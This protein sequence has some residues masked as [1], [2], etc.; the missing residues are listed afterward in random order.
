MA[1][2][3]E[4]HR[5]LDR[6]SQLGE[7]IH[8]AGEIGV[9]V[10]LHGLLQRIG[11]HRQRVR[12]HP[13]YQVVELRGGRGVAELC[14]PDVADQKDVG[15]Y[16]AHRERR[17]AVR[18]DQHHPLRTQHHADAQLLGGGREIA[19][20]GGRKFRAAGHRSD[21]NRCGQSLAQ[22]LGGQVNPGEAG[23]GQRHIRQVESFQ[24][25]GSGDVLHWIAQA[26]VNVALLAFL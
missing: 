7:P 10:G 9:A 15:C 8:L 22:K 3:L 11:V 26:G 4:E 13:L 17:G 21:E 24:S 18:V 1:D 19:I 23:I 14:Q 16:L 20:D 2:L 25:R 12:P 6:V 5:K